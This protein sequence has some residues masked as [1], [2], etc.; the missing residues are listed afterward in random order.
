MAWIAVSDHRGDNLSFR[1]LGR[2][3][4]E[5]DLLSHSPDAIMPRGSLVVETRLSAAA[6]PEPLVYY[7]RPGV[8]PFHFS[9]QSIP[10]GGVAL[11]F[12]QDGH[13][14]HRTID[15]TAPGRMDVLRIT[16]SWDAP[17]RWARLAVERPD[18]GR[19]TVEIIASPKPLPVSDLLTL[20][21]AGPDRY[22]APDVVFLALS[23]GIEPIG[24]SP[25]LHPDTPVA[26]PEGYRPVQALVRG[27]TILSADGEVVPVLHQ[28][29]RTVPARGTF[30]PL[31][32][33][34][35]YFGL[36]K[37]VLVSASQRLVL[38]GSDVEYLFGQEAVMTSAG[39]LLGG[40]SVLPEGWGATSTYSQVILPGHEPLDL[41]GTVGESLYVGRIS[42]KPRLLEASLMANLPRSSLPDH[43][44]PSHQLLHTFDARILAERRV[45]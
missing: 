25:S 6:E 35:P 15:E 28:I 2:P 22:L 44:R 34:S 33:R 37:D 43:R 19:V 45:A 36:R 8:W 13:L 30:A 3:T 31:R 39:N 24:P 29:C 32:L 5:P 4:S 14:L 1:G 20:M 42:R 17:Q 16:Y 27:D 26:T 10:G 40:T 9:L 41:A 21:Q 11:V 38:S 23:D 7:D 18:L 12:N